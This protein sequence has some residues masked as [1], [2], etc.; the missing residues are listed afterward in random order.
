MENKI[1][2]CITPDITLL[3]MLVRAGYDVKY[4]ANISLLPSNPSFVPQMILIDGL[5]VLP[6]EIRL[7]RTLF[8]RL[9]HIIVRSDSL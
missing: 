5:R 6:E 7:L 9:S 3:G 4:F 8:P 2:I 1:I